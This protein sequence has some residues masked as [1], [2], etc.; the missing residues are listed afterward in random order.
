VKL[1]KIVF[2]G[3]VSGIFG[4]GR[5]VHAITTLPETQLRQVR[6]LDVTDRGLVVTTLD[7]ARKF[8]PSY[9]LGTGDV[10]TEPQANAQANAQAKGKT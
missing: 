2:R 3:D 9:L 7:G 5:D 10:L 1:S 4:D 8:V 6:E